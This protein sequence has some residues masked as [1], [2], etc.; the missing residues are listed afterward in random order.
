[1]QISLFWNKKLLYALLTFLCFGITAILFNL[2][3]DS[4]FSD[5]C[6]YVFLLPYHNI[7]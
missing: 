7:V 6:R 5:K 4:K 3:T 1:M 2:L